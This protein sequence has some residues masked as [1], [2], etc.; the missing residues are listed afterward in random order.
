MLKGSVVRAL[1]V[2][3]KATGGKLPALEM[4]TQAFAANPLSGTGLITAIALLQ[5]LFF[6]TLHRNSLE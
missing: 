3:R 5:M 2:P 1:G 4:I 6:F